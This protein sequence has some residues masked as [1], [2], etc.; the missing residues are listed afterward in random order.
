MKKLL[1]I[2]VCSLM[3][4]PAFC[5]PAKKPSLM[6]VPSRVWCE[7]NGFMTEYDNMGTMVKIPDYQAAFDG[8]SELNLA[9]R[10]IGEMM[11]DRGFDLRLMS[12][13][14]Q[15]I[16]NEAAEEMLMSSKS[17][18]EIQES[19]VDKLKKVA[20]ADIWMEVWWEVNTVGFQKS[21]TFDLTGID[22]YTDTQ[23]AHCGDTGAP[24]Y[25]AELPVLL[26]E[27]I[28]NYLDGFNEQ[29]FNKFQDWFD[30]GRQIKL[31]VKCWSDFEYDL[32]EEFD[33]EELGVLI[34]DWV[35]ENTVKGQ[36]TTD[37][38]TESMMVFSNVR[39]PMVTE[40]GKAIDARRWGRG[41]QKMLRD[42]YEITAKVTTKG[43]G[44]VTVILG[45]K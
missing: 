25:S 13:A 44:Q 23:M 19:P 21:V 28:T 40:D 14:L 24:S 6:V 41:L 29:L 37:D 22:A 3:A 12:A 2:L 4:L 7:K 1:L 5:Q 18:A 34:E 42:K 20:K 39:I 11:S 17:G 43:L 36:F 16:Q 10:K 33:G 15:T 8:S 32:E 31:Q 26:S 45:G 35:G 9:V 27:T 38:A 30:N